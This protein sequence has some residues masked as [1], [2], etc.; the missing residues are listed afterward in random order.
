MR[1]TLVLASLLALTACT[2]DADTAAETAPPPAP[3]EASTT[4]AP[5]AT[6][7]AP[8]DLP[9]GSIGPVADLTGLEA[10]RQYREIQGGQAYAPLDEKV[11]VVEV[12]NYVCPACAAFQPLVNTWKRNLAPDVRFEYVPADFRPTW[13]PYVRAFYTA[14]ALGVV[15]K[16]HDAV[17][18]AIHV[19]RTLQGERGVDTPQAIAAVYARHGV[20]AATFASTMSSF[21]IDARANRAKQFLTRNQVSSTPTMIVDGRYA[22]EG[23]SFEEILANTSLLI[24]RARAA[25]RAATTAPAPP[26]APAATG[27]PATPPAS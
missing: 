14:Q 21:A 23:E 8:T 4:P 3:A 20:D 13:S 1:L 27:A 10:G 9:P 5:A 16:T 17:F 2:R 18:N 26:P 11:E 19:E 12:F 6:P 22:A 7:A 25:R 15:D 24:E